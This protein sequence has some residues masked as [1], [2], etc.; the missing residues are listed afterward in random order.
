MTP[1]DVAQLG[2]QIDAELDAIRRCVFQI[3]MAGRWHIGKATDV[4]ND[5]S[6][7][8]THVVPMDESETVLY[9]SILEGLIVATKAQ[10]ELCGTLWE[11]TAPVRS[12]EYDM[13]HANL[14]S[15][16]ERFRFR[17]KAYERTVRQTDKPYLRQANALVNESGD[18]PEVQKLE[19]ILRLSL[20][21]FIELEDRIQRTLARLDA[22]RELLADGHHD[23]AMQYAR[24]LGISDDQS[25][26][27]VLLSLRKASGYY[28]YKQGY[29]FTEY[30]RHWI[31]R[32]LQI[33]D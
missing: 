26:E 11:K 10:N 15:L 29:A 27:S 21:E 14:C 30:A 18:H 4:L 12:G 3:G 8:E 33:P 9:L 23:F 25:I 22:A 16:F 24:S 20:R 17:S 1:D 6:L 32:A 7:V 5:H 28:D 2:Q 19:R 31:N 13:E